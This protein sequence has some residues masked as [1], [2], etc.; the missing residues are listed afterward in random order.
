MV[1]LQ[2]TFADTIQLPSSA[3]NSFMVQLQ[4]ILKSLFSTVQ[5]DFQFLHGTITRKPTN[6]KAILPHIFQFLHGTITRKQA[7]IKL[8]AKAIFQFLHGTITSEVDNCVNVHIYPFNSFMVQLQVFLQN[9]LFYILKS[10]N[11]FMVQL[12]V[13]C[14]LASP[15][16]RGFQFLHGTITSKGCE[17]CFP[18]CYNFQFLHGT[19]TSN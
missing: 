3:F 11:S 1:Q 12:Q 9:R 7:F 18:R 13:V 17:S 19:I 6:W 16:L 10:F 2:V 8:I 5:M 4:V 14:A 15:C